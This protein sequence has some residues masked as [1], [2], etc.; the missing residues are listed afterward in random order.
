MKTVKTNIT[1][2][3]KASR[4]ELLV[5]IVYIIPL[6]IILWAFSILA[7]IAFAILWFH[8]LIFGKRHRGSLSF[9]MKYVDYRFKVY[10]YL[11][12]LTEERTPI[13]P[14]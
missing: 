3:E 7:S 13:F 9:L 14:E 11:G 2:K 8:I 6:G 4:L 10:A 5:R 1:Y 12:M